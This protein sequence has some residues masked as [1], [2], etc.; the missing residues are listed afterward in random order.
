[1]RGLLEASFGTVAMVAD[2]RSLLDVACR[3]APDVAVVD[4]SITRDGGLDWLKA[5]RTACPA[6]KLVAISVHDEDSVRQAVLGAGADEFVVKRAM[7][8]DLL[9]AVER[10]RGPGR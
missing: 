4:V 2:E 8:T 1:M 7:A 6:L 3:L 9:P 5:L 10:L